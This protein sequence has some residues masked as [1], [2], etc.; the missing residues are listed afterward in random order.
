MSI[1]YNVLMLSLYTYK[2]AK[3]AQQQAIGM[4]ERDVEISA[5]RYS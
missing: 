5:C 1:K 2:N 3:F 4:E